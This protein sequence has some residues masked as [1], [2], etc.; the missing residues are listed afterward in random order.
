MNVQEMITEVSSGLGNRTDITNSRYVAWLNWSIK[1]LASFAIHRR[2][3]LKYFHALEKSLNFQ[4]VVL[5]GTMNAA[6]ATD[7]GFWLDLAHVS[8][9]ADFYKD[10]VIEIT[11]YSGTAPDGLVGQ[12]RTIPSS[13]TTGW[14]EIDT[15]WVVTPDS[16]TEYSLYKRVYPI[17]VSPLN[18]E[19]AY[20]SF[21]AVQRMENI[22]DGTMLTHKKWLDL[23]GTA[24]TSVGTPAAFA[25]RGNN[26]IFDTTPDTAVWFRLWFYAFPAAISATN[27]TGYTDIPDIWHEAIVLG[28]IYRGHRALMEPDRAQEARAAWYDEI[29]NTT[30]EIELEGMHEENRIRMR[31]S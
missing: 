24:F 16:N 2:L 14:C 25:R 30:D 29:A 4:T 12:I 3:D 31:F 28:A 26:I 15:D 18:A 20:D 6:P 23:M 8:A 13:L 22:A 21:W 7:N 27:L 11:G 19:S 5:D 17:G 9:T 1:R 10:Y